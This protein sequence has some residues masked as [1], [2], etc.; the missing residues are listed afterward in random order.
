MIARIILWGVIAGLVWFLIGICVLAAIDDE[1]YRL[2]QWVS[3]APNFIIFVLAI[4]AWPLICWS[5]RKR[6]CKGVDKNEQ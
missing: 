6:F 2:Y 1:E 5:W 3:S 4:S